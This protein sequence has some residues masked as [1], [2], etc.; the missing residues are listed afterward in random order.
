MDAK[1][2]DWVVTARQGRPVELNAL[3]YSALRIVA[4][5]CDE[6]GQPR[7]GAELG[8]LADRVKLAFNR[9]FWHEHSGCL[10]DVVTD[11]GVDASIRPNQLLA[12]SLPHAVL[13]VSRHAAVLE[14]VTEHLLT[15]VGLRTLSPQDPA[16]QRAYG[17][18]VV[19]R[20]RAYHQGSAYPWLLGPYVAALLRVRG[21]GVEV[22]AEALDC[23]RGCLHHLEDHYGQL[24]ELFDGDAPHRPGGA[25]ASARNVGAILRCYVEDVL[26]VA[27]V[28]PTVVPSTRVAEDKA[29]WRQGD[30]A[31]KG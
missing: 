19:S 10:Y 14:C 16:Y 15:S 27:P 12:I 11:Y 29:T 18:D 24:C 7:R 20:D 13:D 22:R 6:A 4:P 1:V 26:N 17:G 9:A 31:T 28:P 2:G 5:W 8:A 3:W 23:L 21:R 25:I 30:T